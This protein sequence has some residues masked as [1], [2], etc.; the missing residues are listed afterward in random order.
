MRPT[1]LPDPYLVAFNPSAAALAIVDSD[2]PVYRE[3]LETAA[4]LTRMA[5]CH[6][7][8]GSF[9]ASRR[10]MRNSPRTCSG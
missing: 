9:E 3:S 2:A 10:A 5:P 1:P 8:F 6:V 7:R 4:V